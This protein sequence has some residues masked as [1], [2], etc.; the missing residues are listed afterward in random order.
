MT[1]DKADFTQG[2]ILKKLVAFMM[3]LLQTDC[4]FS[5]SSKSPVQRLLSEIPNYYLQF[6]LHQTSGLLADILSESLSLLPQSVC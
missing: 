1:N 2:N 4:F 6:F 3:P 5:D